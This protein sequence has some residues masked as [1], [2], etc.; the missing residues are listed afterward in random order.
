MG[1]EWLTPIRFEMTA[2]QLI[3]IIITEQCAENI[4]SA[5]ELLNWWFR[6]Y[7]QYGL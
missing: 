5:I 1:E 7:P 3:D 4:S 2:A 6:G